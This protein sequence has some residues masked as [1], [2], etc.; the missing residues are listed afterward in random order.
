MW[1]EGGHGLPFPLWRQGDQSLWV[2]GS[3]GAMAMGE[4]WCCLARLFRWLLGSSD[5][6][7]ASYVQLLPGGHR[8]APTGKRR[9]HFSE[10][11]E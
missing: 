10:M 4:E 7:P 2:I 11:D 3:G 6:S 1:G 8:A 5:G 9:E